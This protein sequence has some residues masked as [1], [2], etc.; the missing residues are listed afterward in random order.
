[1]AEDHSVSALRALRHLRRAT[2]KRSCY[3][4]CM[5]DTT[6]PQGL[7]F[8]GE[9]VFDATDFY[10]GIVDQ[11]IGG[12]AITIVREADAS[13]VGDSQSSDCPNERLVNVAIDDDWLGE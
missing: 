10:I 12:A 11:K 6:A 7:Q 2:L 3:P 5:R 1:M 4:V 9:I 8:S 13:R